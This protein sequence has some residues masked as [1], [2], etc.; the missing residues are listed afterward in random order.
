MNLD[1]YLTPIIKERQVSYD[2]LVI[3]IEDHIYRLRKHTNIVGILTDQSQIISSYN[4]FCTQIEKHREI[5]KIARKQSE[6]LRAVEQEF[7]ANVTNIS[8]LVIVTNGKDSA[9]YKQLFP[10]GLSEYNG[11]TKART[12]DSLIRFRDFFNEYV[13]LYGILLSNKYNQLLE[14]YK[15]SLEA[16]KK[17]S[18][19]LKALFEQK[20]VTKVILIENFHGLFLDNLVKNFENMKVVSTLYNQDL[21]KT[22]TGIRR[23]S[24]LKKI[25]PDCTA[26]ILRNVYK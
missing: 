22:R 8:S 19:L 2:N 4:Q 3:F 12:I 7:R 13:E 20:Q 6:N 9:H 11:M 1:K 25:T 24:V 21:L 23:K 5:S 26:E 10:N 17:Y 16:Q 15:T 18:I 14:S